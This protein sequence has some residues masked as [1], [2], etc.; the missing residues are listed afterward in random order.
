MHNSAQ[1]PENMEKVRIRIGIKQDLFLHRQFPVISY[2]ENRKRLF[3]SCETIHGICQISPYTEIRI[4]SPGMRIRISVY[5]G[6]D[7]P[8]EVSGQ[9]HAY[10]RRAY[11]YLP[12]SGRFYS[13]KPTLCLI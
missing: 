1:K 9:I 11:P 5:I 8:L 12:D 4:P 13:L 7:P 10:I 3:P 6:M 2:N